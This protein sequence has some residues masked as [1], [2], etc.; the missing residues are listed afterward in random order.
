[1]VPRGP[2]QTVI[3]ISSAGGIIVFPVVVLLLTNNSTIAIVDVAGLSGERTEKLSRHYH[4]NMV[5]CANIPR[6]TYLY[7][8]SAHLELLLLES[9][10]AFVSNFNE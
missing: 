7:F 3:K 9:I 2:E 10:T 4:Y 1:V 8:C 5:Y 6:G